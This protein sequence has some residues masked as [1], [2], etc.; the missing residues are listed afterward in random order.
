VPVE[1]QLSGEE[2]EWLVRAAVGPRFAFMPATVVAALVAAGLAEMNLHG[3][4]DVNAAGRRYIA[5]RSLSTKMEKRRK[6]EKR[7]TRW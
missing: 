7:S 5:E 2:E 4:L 3:T 1:P 6:I